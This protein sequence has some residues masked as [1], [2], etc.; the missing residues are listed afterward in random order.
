MKDG[1]IDEY[2]FH[3][4]VNVFEGRESL[5]GFEPASEVIGCDEVRE[6]LSKLLMALVVE[7]LDCGFLDG[8]VH[9]L[10]LAVIRYVIRG[11]FLVRLCFSKNSV[12]VC[13]SGT[14]G[15]G[16]TKVRAGRR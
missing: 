2:C 6:M 15:A 3:L 13:P 16:S 12:M 11:A 5:H 8:P 9:S 1:G 7:A 10:N 4:A 14:R